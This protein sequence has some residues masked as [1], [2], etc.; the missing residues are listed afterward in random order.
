MKKAYIFFADGFEDIE[1]LMVVDLFRRA[2]IDIRTV[3][4][5][6]R[7]E[8]VTSHKVPLKCD[9]LMTEE[10]FEDADLLILPGGKAGTENL[11]ACKPLGELLTKHYQKGTMLAAICAAPT[12]FSDLG[13]LKG[14]KATSYPTC[15]PNIH[16]GQYLTDPVV[17]DGTITTSRGLGTSLDFALN[18]ISQ[19]LDAQTAEKIAASV[20]YR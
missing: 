7:Q 15:E 13:F 19:L 18:L 4:I 14:R 6:D 1:G 8:I 11:R 3:S 10:S 12:V 5:T 9:T 17:V 16:A 2:G 20:V